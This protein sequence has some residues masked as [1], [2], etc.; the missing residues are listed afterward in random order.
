VQAL[1]TKEVIDDRS[2]INLQTGGRETI[3]TATARND[4]WPRDSESGRNS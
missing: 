1:Q 3:E 2:S 4:S